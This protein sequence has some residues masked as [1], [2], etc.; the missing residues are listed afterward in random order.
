MITERVKNYWTLRA[1][2]FGVVRKNE[3]GNEMSVRWLEEIERHLPAE[4]VLDVLDVG[5]G[6]GFF[7]VI[8]ALRGHRVHGIDLTPAM[9]D[10]SVALAKEKNLDITFSQMDAQKLDFE[11][12]SFDLVI[13]RNLTWTLPDP[14]AAY[15]EWHRVLRPGGMLLNYDA[16]YGEHVRSESKQNS[17]V[18]PDSPYGHV[19]VTKEMSEESN[20]ITLAMEISREKRPQWD[21]QVLQAIGFKQCTT[22][23]N[24]GMRVLQ[25]LDLQSAPMFGICAIK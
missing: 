6:T 2:D 25:N 5:T 23:C 3:L 24:V 8:L 18:P 12:E 13:S 10:E 4:K 16:N 20:A 14:E 22:D 19:G 1:H 21:E 11:S 9:I 17:D 7:A 15:K